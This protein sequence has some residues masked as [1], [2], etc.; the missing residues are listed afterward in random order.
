MKHTTFPF[1]VLF[2]PIFSFAQNKVKIKINERPAVYDIYRN[3]TLIGSVKPKRS[4]RYPHFEIAAHYGIATYGHIRGVSGP[5][6][7]I[8]TGFNKSTIVESKGSA[9]KVLF[10]GSVFVS[11]SV[12]IGLIYSQNDIRYKGVEQKDINH[13]VFSPVSRGGI[14]S[15]YHYRFPK[16]EIN[17][18]GSIST[19]WTNKINRYQ[20][21]APNK[22]VNGRS[23]SVM[24]GVKYRIVKN[25]YGS[26]QVEYTE[27][28]FD[29]SKPFQTSTNILRQYG[30]VLG[31]SFRF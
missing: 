12:D 29:G 5:P 24:L 3:D 22:R 2:A 10:S 18:G 28:M 16:W 20:I 9:P 27:D 30:G 31:L 6:Y 4:Y 17:A 19:L 26:A 1:L 8:V 23:Y 7:R 11:K 13:H 25:F 21:Y 14:F 15:R